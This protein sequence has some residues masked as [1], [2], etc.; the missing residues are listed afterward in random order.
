M[1][2]YHNVYKAP[3]GE[4]TQWDDIQRKMGNLPARE[5]VKP[6]DPWKPEGKHRKNKEW[7]DGQVAEDLEEENDAFDD[8]R[9]LE[10]YRC[11]F[12]LVKHSCRPN[13]PLSHGMICTH[14]LRRL[15]RIEQ[16]KQA[17]K[18]AR[19]GTVEQINRSDFVHQVTNAGEDVWVVVH[20]YKDK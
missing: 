12:L 13:Q 2:D 5:P 4:T 9:F 6:A 17:Q 20:L 10:Q 15:E 14:A 8:D 18:Q 1:G 3:E 19:F 7:V 11:M 16:L